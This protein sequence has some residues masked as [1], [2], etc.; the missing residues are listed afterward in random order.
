MVSG[1][2]GIVCPRI[3][4]SIMEFTPEPSPHSLREELIGP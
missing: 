3:D 1:D 4:D 2:G